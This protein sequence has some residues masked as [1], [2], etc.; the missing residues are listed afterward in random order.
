VKVK[1]HSSRSPMRDEIAL[2]SRRR[3]VMSEAISELELSINALLIVAY[4]LEDHELEE[5][6]RK[7]LL[8]CRREVREAIGEAAT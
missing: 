1:A 7:I 2:G 8:R 4:D 6:L 3:S 5:K